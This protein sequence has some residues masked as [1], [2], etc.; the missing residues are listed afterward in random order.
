MSALTDSLKWKFAVEAQRDYG[1][2]LEDAQLMAE[3][4]SNLG[5]EMLKYLG[6]ILARYRDQ[7]YEMIKAE[8]IAELHN[9]LSVGS[10]FMRRATVLSKLK[11]LGSPAPKPRRVLQIEAE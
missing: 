10:T 2:S 6:P 1:L 9:H 11:A 7:Q 5:D 4:F 3:L 8:V